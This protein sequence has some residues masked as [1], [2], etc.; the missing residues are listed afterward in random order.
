[1]TADVSGITDGT[2]GLTTALFHYQWIRVDGTAETE[3]DGETGATYTP[4]AADV[5]KHLK[6]RVIFDDDAGN[7]EYPRTSRQVGPVVGH[8]EVTV[9]FAQGSYAVAEGDSVT[10]TVQLSDDPEREVV[11]RLTAT[12]EGG[13][14][15]SATTSRPRRSA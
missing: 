3:L 7:R 1:M 11:A 14:T 6:V 9:G 10:V 12:N 4:T 15:S 13:A 2:D 8:P 5:G